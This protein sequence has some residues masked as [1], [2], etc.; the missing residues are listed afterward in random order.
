MKRQLVDAIGRLEQD[1]V[2]AWNQ[3]DIPKACETYA[4]DAL[5]ITA[6]GIIA[7]KN[8]IAAHY[9][10]A[11]GKD[12]ST[13]GTL[14]LDLD[15]LLENDDAHTALASLRWRLRIGDKNLRGLA[16]VKYRIDGDVVR[17]THDMSI[18]V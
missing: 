13:M 9:Q 16:L 3:G 14:A 7:G 18:S 8:N 10:E 12:P 4:D 11:Y 1:F 17:V 15:V 2:N 5:F 6:K